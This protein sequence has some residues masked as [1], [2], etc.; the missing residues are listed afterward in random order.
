[1]SLPLVNHSWARLLFSKIA[2]FSQ[3]P[4]NVKGL[5]S[6]R[7]ISEVRGVNRVVYE[8]QAS[9]RLPS[10]GSDFAGDCRIV[11]VKIIRKYRKYLYF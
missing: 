2:D 5:T 8:Y 3:I 10:S 4:Y 1:M 6:I 11:G 9:L 7:I